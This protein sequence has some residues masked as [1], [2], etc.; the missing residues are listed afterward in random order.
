[1][2][3]RISL[4]KK[5][6]ILFFVFLLPVITYFLLKSGQNMYKPLPVY[7]PKEVASTFHLK[8]GRK[9]QDTIYHTIS[10]Y[11]SADT[12]KIIMANFLLTDD[13]FGNKAAN[14]QTWRLVDY[15][16]KNP[17]L[18]FVTYAANNQW[19]VD[20]NKNDN[21]KVIYAPIDSLGSIA[22]QQYLLNEVKIDSLTKK[23]TASRRFIMLDQH[24]RIRGFYRMENR[25]N[26][27]TLMDEVKVL[28]VELIREEDDKKLK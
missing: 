7:G 11:P 20:S 24:H 17:K 19:L 10:Y 12:G 26:I 1:M 18:Q 6:V 14:E 2:N 21:W 4:S 5:A 3:T 8:K 9:I 15:F 22:Q 27:D 16:K 23:Y 13:A 28:T 25:Y